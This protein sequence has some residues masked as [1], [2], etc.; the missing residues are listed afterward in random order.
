MKQH[1]MILPAIMHDE[2]TTTTTDPLRLM[3]PT[4]FEVFLEGARQL[5]DLCNSS[6]LM[7]APGLGT[8]REILLH[9]D[10]SSPFSWNSSG[11]YY[12]D[13][14]YQDDDH[15]ALEL[16]SLSDSESLLR[17]ELA[18]IDLGY[19]I[20]EEDGLSTTVY[21]WSS[22]SPPQASPLGWLK[23]PLLTCMNH[24]TTSCNEDD[25]DEDYPLDLEDAWN[26]SNQTSNSNR[27]TIRSINSPQHEEEAEEEA[28][29]RVL[30]TYKDYSSVSSSRNLRARVVSIYWR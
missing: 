3:S 1:M 21:P 11:N 8:K 13:S 4:L 22:S 14:C 9:D 29:T 5:D 25:D 30:Q 7:K 23:S 20:R 16:A 19:S 28:G 27:Q 2:T 10:D 17:L 26:G 12:K 24:H 6:T 18:A 15:L